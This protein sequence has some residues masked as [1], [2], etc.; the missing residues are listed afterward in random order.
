MISRDCIESAY[1]FFHQKQ[2]VYEYSTLD[3]Q[4]DD[5]E[6]AISKYVNGMDM[7]LYRLLADGKEDFLL[8][9]T[10]FASDLEKAVNRLDGLM[11]TEP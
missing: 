2:R 3:W 9:H 10:C 4:K 1:C 8:D 6:L 11:K 7:N 5:I